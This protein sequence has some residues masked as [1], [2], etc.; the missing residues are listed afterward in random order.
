MQDEQIARVVVEPVGPQMRGGFGIDQLGVDADPVARPADTSF[1]NVSYPQ[2]VA[3]LLRIDPLV[4]ISE[5][6]VTRD[7]EHIRKSRQIGCQ[8]LR[9]PVRE[10][11]LL[12]IVAEVRKGQ[13]DDRQAWHSDGRRT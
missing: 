13:D 10:I 12:T 2:L 11:L 4:L 1:E 5:R 6:G 7:H 9:D 8:I 3:D